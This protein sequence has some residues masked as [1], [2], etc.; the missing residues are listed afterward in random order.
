MQGHSSV[1]QSTEVHLSSS[2]EEAVK[3]QPSAPISLLSH[4]ADS[5]P[6]VGLAQ[7]AK[8]EA[9]AGALHHMQGAEASARGSL[10]DS[11]PLRQ[12]RRWPQSSCRRVP[13]LSI[14]S[15]ACQRLKQGPRMP[16]DASRRGNTARRPARRSFLRLPLPL[17]AVLYLGTPV[18]RTLRSNTTTST[19][20]RYP[21]S[22]TVSAMPMRR[23]PNRPKCKLHQRWREL[24]SPQCVPRALLLLA[25]RLERRKRSR[26]MPSARW[27]R[28]VSG[29]GEEGGLSEAEEDSQLYGSQSCSFDRVVLDSRR[30]RASLRRCE[31]RRSASSRPPRRSTH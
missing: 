25:F 27:K 10:I 15:R 22:S 11:T 6:C 26:G 21:S 17:P 13:R 4:A 24:H 28:S 3:G 18:S 9:I 23:P 16:Q 12:W 2:E 5:M 19:P 20:S 30:P 29:K 1:T 8:F 31:P 7:S 14:V